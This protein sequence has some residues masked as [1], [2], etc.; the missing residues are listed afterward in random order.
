MKK[1][2]MCMLLAVVMMLGMFPGTALAASSEEEALGEV[3]IY[4]GGYPLSYLSINGRVR[5]LIYTYYNYVDRNGQVKEIPAYCVNPNTKGVPQTVAKGE[6]IKYLAKEIGSDPKVVGIVANGYPTRSLGELGLE[7]KYQGYYATKMALWCYLLSHWDINNLKV[8]SSLTGVEL[9]RANKILAAAKDIYRR[10]TA[11]PEVR[12][13][14]LTS[15]ADRSTAYAVTINGQPYYQQVFT[16]HSDTWVCNYDIAVSFTDPSAVPE[17]AKIVDMN[18][19]EIS[20]VTTSGTGSGYDGKFKVI[21]PA[22]SIEGEA[23]SVQ[24]SYRATVYNYGVYYAVCA[25]VDKYG[26]L[27]NYMCDTDPVVPIAASDYSTYSTDDEDEEPYDT[28]LKIVKLEAGTEIPLSGAIFEVVDPEGA[29]IGSFS[30]NSK[31][32]IV[33]PLSKSGNY[34]VYERVAPSHYLLSEEPARNVKV[35]YGEQAKITFENEPYGTLRVNKYSNTGMNLPGAVIQVEHI[36]TGTKYTTETNFAGVAIFDEIKPGAYRIVEISSPAGYLKTDEVFTANVVA[37]ETVSIPI[38]NEEMPGLRILKYDSKDQKALP[39]VTFEIF[40]DAVSLGKFT[41]DE[42]GEILLTNLEP[43][44]Y[45]AQ[46]VAT[47]DSHILCSNPQQIE[48]GGGDGIKELIFFNDQKP[49]IHLV[50][51]DSTTLEPLANARFKIELVG[52]TFSKEYVTDQNG[53]VDLTDLEPGAYQ[54][55]ELAAP[56][57]YLI[58]DATRVIQINGNE[59]ASFVFTNT[60]KPSF[61][62]VKLDSYTGDPLGGATFRIAKIED[63]THYLDRVTDTNGEINI[64]DL[65]PGVYSVV[66]MKAPEGYVADPMEYHVELFPGQVSELVVSNDRKPTLEIIKTDAITGAPVE[67]VNFTVKKVDSSTL[68]TVTSDEDGKCYIENLDPGVYEVWEQSVPDD[69]LLNEEHQLITL[70][71]NRMGTVQF[72]NYPK[73]TL[74]VNKIDSITGDP[75]KGAK[76][77]V[78]FRS[79]KTST[80]E[81]RELGTY[82]SDENG[83]FKLSKLDDGWYTIKE[84]EP[85]AGYSIKEPAEQEIYVEAGRG[86]TVTFENTPLSAIIVK[87]VDSATGDP[88]QGAWFRVRFLGGTSGTGGTIIAERQTSSNGTFVLT[89]LKAGT[90]V[91]EE[92]SAPDGYVLS[93][94]D[95]QTVYLSGKDQDVITVTFGNEAKGSLLIKKIDAVTR[96]PLSDVEFMVTASDGTVIGNSNGRYVTDSAGTILIDGLDPNMTVVVKEGRPKDGYVLDDVPQSIKIKS[97]ETVS[98]EFRNYPEGTLHITKKDAFTKEPLAGVEF[99]VTTSDGTTIGTNNGRYTTDSSGS[100]VIPNLEPEMTVIIKETKAKAG[101][102]LDDT[103]QQ[104][105]IKSNAVVTVEFLNQ[106]LGSLQ[107]I[108]KD[109]ATREPLEGVQFMVTKTDGAVVGNGT[110]LYTTDADGGIIINGLEPEMTVIV[111]EVKAKDGYLL[112][113]TPKQATIKSNEVTTLEFLNQPLGGLRI[114][115]LD[116]VT[117]KPL[118]CV[119]FKVTYADG[120]YVPDEGGKLSSNGIYKTDSN[121]EILISDLVGT[122]V[123]T[124]TKTIPGYVIDENTRSQTVVINP[125]DL[126]TLTFYN[127]PS[128]GLQIIKS[129]EDTGK[130]IS[131][132]KFEI[133]KINGE[134]I[135]T[136]TTDRNGVISIPEAESGWYNITELKAAAGYELDTTPVQAC[137]KDGQTTT[138]E[139]TNQ[140][141][142]SIMIHKVDANTGKGIYGVKFVIYDSGKNPIMEV[143]TDQDGYAWVNNELTPGKYYIRELEAAEGYIRDEQ[144]KTVYVEAGK[145]AQIEWENTAVTG[146]I[147]IRKYAQEDNS[148]TGVKAGSPLEGA[149]YEITQARSGAVVGYIVT[150][151][152][153]VAAS[154]PLTLGRYYVTEV[155]APKYYQLNSEKMEAEIEYPNQIIKL[156]QYDK[157]AKVGV[158]IKKTGNYEVQPGQV[159]TYDFSGIANT[160]NVALNNFYWHDRLPTDAVR[161]VS[162][163]TGTYNQRLYYKVTFKTNL[164]DYRTLA[165]NLLTTNNYSLSLNATTLGLVQGE[166]VTDVRFEFGT[167]PS[168]FASVVKPTMRVQ[169]LGTVSN[170]YQ[171]INRADVG[172]KY[173]NEWETAKATW[174]TTVRRFNSTPLPKTG[175]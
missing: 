91:V 42:F 81:I 10:G 109:S 31:G 142:A 149:V 41:T 1:R 166:Y 21:Y 116:S 43:G 113:D 34:T 137:V 30:T 121:G 23:G 110:G 119:E 20:A 138:V 170:G 165:S 49:G 17:G 47:D 82:Y 74:T 107:I 64:S 120:S 44:T 29:S 153:G 111:K 124:E 67:G 32:E 61:R 25:E 94:D 134:I 13:P 175:Y 122:V 37:G 84:L 73:P 12:R 150:D 131:G 33:I 86:K 148:I 132:V 53:E 68:T 173:L 152:R 66:E 126:Q 95:I 6:S 14:R 130:R 11:W 158:T 79:D 92:I 15:E 72:Q 69:Y 159:M 22:S 147:Q 144:Y 60:C 169:V 105:V 87:K 89:G 85:A 88:L 70:V 104:A 78:T 154:D 27:Q 63:G 18:N 36:E 98:L 136:Y 128:G 93:E 125:N 80:G 28:S 83:Q 106:P 117:H 161:G 19:N 103:P 75:I 102:I 146:Q 129:D 168:G 167:V 145:C 38:V 155:S 35:I 58:D 133:R 108:K 40:K 143:E 51:L 26:N 2:V 16:L 127:T 71:P 112:D 9:E 90:Y 77:S 141:M 164:N 62:L 57:G 135:G 56:D 100:I 118:E 157:S 114:V 76:F 160:S 46:E 59:N 151:A 101:Y 48:I 156:S 45:L 163:S 39:G 174:I 123:V 55:I 97:G 24:L 8:N 140:R 4:N 50:K 96:E 3:D 171:I 99:L 65:E 115:K 5:E 162:L 7:N 139:I 52:G 54:V 172:G